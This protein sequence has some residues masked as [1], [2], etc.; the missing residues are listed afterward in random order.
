MM[1]PESFCLA[2]CL[3]QQLVSFVNSIAWH[4]LHFFQ[5]PHRI[6]GGKHSSGPLYPM[7]SITSLV[8]FVVARLFNIS[9]KRELVSLPLRYITHSS[10][11]TCDWVAA[12]IAVTWL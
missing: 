1:P 2:S 6:A 5:L 10:L 4:L 11:S 12:S 8:G 3:H 7:I 9:P